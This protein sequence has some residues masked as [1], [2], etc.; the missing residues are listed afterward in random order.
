MKRPGSVLAL[1]ILALWP[2]LLRAE[3]MAELDRT[4]VSMGDSLTLTLRATDKENFRSIDLAVLQRDFT[5]TNTKRNSRISSVNGKTEFI[6]ELELTISPR[7]QG[8]LQIPAFHVDGSLSNPI[9]VR[10]AAAAGRPAADDSVFLEVE[11]DRESVYVQAQLIF[12]FRVYRS[13]QVDDLRLSPLELPGVVI[14]SLGDNSFQRN[15]NGKTYLVTELKYALFPQQ[16][17]VL[18]IPSLEF[19]GRGRA[20]RLSRSLIRQRTQELS[21]QV[22][23]IP[24]QFPDATWLPSRQLGIEDDWSV[25]PA[26]LTLGDSVTRTIT[27][28]A[29]G[30][31]GNQLPAVELD[32]AP[33]IKVYQDQP[34]FQNLTDETGVKGLGI[35]TAALLIVAAGEYQLQPVRIP[36]WDTDSDELRYAELPALNVSIAPAA[37]NPNTIADPA[38]STSAGEVTVG[39]L[40]SAGASI[41]YWATLLCGLGWLVTTVAL[42]RRRP[43]SMQAVATAAESA[44]AANEKKLFNALKSTAVGGDSRALRSAILLWGQTY[45]AAPHHRALTEIGKAIADQAVQREFELMEQSLFAADTGSWQATALVEQLTRWRAN[46]TRPATTDLKPP[47]PALYS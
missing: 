9:N 43:V 47:L 44:A 8:N 25:E 3:L 46:N 31:S 22:K 34:K 33:G 37:V 35:S 10:V 38:L 17:G 12:S 2:S 30:I 39:I 18:N 15:V 11:V 45:F 7:R 1:C 6:S 42:W 23:P 27:L 28:T 14:E 13:V 24:V 5:I 21:V 36:W 32:T 29:Q 4:Q 20:S 16:S 40:G 41:W 19:T 26:S